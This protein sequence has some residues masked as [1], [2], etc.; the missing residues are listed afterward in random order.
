[1]KDCLPRHKAW[2]LLASLREACDQIIRHWGDT[3]FQLGKLRQRITLNGLS[4]FP[5]QKERS[6]LNWWFFTPLYKSSDNPILLPLPGLWEIP[7]SQQKLFFSL[8]NNCMTQILLSLLNSVNSPFPL[9]AP[10][11]TLLACPPCH[12]LLAPYKHFGLQPPKFLLFFSFA[13]H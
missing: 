3:C 4:K 5:V 2:F 9:P 13:C 6:F 12:W 11:S 1:M 10:H 8:C 7:E